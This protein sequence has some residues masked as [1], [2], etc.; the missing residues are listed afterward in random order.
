M[1]PTG[2][3]PSIPPGFPM[4]SRLSRR[5][6]EKERIDRKDLKETEEADERRIP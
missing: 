2:R 4:K 1:R 3:R 6:K 5:K